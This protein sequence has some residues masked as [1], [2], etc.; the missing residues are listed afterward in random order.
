MAIS[1]RPPAILCKI[2]G[3]ILDRKL[4]TVILPDRTFSSPEGNLTSY[5]NLKLERRTKMASDIPITVN[6]DPRGP[7]FIAI[8]K[9]GVEAH[10]EKIVLDATPLE[11]LLEMSCGKK[12]GPFDLP[13]NVTWVVTIRAKGI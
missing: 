2:L 10:K 4:T 6:G 8:A 3:R 5:L 7:Q 11:I 9:N 1:S 13:P 12:F